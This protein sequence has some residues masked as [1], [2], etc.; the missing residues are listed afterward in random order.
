MRVSRD[1]ADAPHGKRQRAREARLW[2]MDDDAYYG[3]A[4]SELFLRLRG[5]AFDAD[6]RMRIEAAHPEWSPR[7]HLELV[8]LQSATLRR[9]LT[10]S[11][12]LNATL[13][14]P[15]LLCAC[16]RHWGLLHACRAPDAPRTM[17]LPFHCPMDHLFEVSRWVG[18]QVVRFREASFLESPRLAPAIRSEVVRLF[19]R[20]GVAEE[21]SAEARFTVG[22]PRGTPMSALPARLF[23]ANPRVRLVEIGLDDLLRLCP[24]LTTEAMTSAFDVR[25]RELLS[26]HGA[27]SVAYCPVEENRAFPGWSLWDGKAPPLNC[28]RLHALPDREL[29]DADGYYGASCRADTLS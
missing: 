24:R 11:H 3:H 18:Q 29:G 19:A 10:L 21:E 7:R 12:A 4:T 20:P 8:A 27:A 16:D 13:V 28:S 6:A 2:R 25:A 9:L 23:R 22:V 17:R 26:G 14:L 5:A 1:G 15:Q